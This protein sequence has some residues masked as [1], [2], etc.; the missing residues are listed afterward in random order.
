ME[1]KEQYDRGRFEG[2]VLAKLADIALK[3]DLLA[4]DSSKL[5]ARVRVLE[6]NKYLLMGIGAVSGAIIGPIITWIISFVK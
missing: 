3:L 5:E 2:E 6:Q 1:Q 4:Q